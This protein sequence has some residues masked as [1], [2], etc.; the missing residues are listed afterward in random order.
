[1]LLA[2]FGPG[3]TNVILVL[4]ISEWVAYARVARAQALQVR[5]VDFVE[6][7]RALGAGGAR[8]MFRHVLP[9]SLSPLIV[10]ASF[11]VA[12]AIIAES[13]LSFLGI[14]VTPDIPTWGG[15][16]ARGRDYVREAW[17]LVTIPG[18]AIALTVLGVNLVGDWLRDQLDPK[19]GR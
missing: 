5:S 13:S 1:A 10:I 12:R 4:A 7:V 15:I 6:A 18:L 11:G 3:L 14:G 19:T 17:W 8:L 2:V 9:N 16:L